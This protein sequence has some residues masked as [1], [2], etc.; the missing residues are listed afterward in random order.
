[1][2]RI[3][4]CRVPLF[5]GSEAMTAIDIVDGRVCSPLHTPLWSCRRVID[6]SGLLL[7]PGIVDIH[8]DAFERQIMPRPQVFFPLETALLETDRQLLANGI[9]TAFHGITCSWEPGLRSM[10]SAR[11][12]IEALRLLRPE[13][14]AEHLVHLRYEVA[15]SK[16]AGTIE[17]W[18][19]E[20]QVH[21][22]SFNDHDERLR[23]KMSSAVTGSTILSRT[24]LTAESLLASLQGLE[25]NEKRAD[26]VAR[27]AAVCRASGIPMASHD[28]DQPQTRLQYHQLGSAICEFPENFETAG[29]A[30]S[31]G[32][33]VVMGA[34]NILR[35]ESH[36]GLRAARDFVRQG[37]C[38]ILSSD[39]YYAG[40]PEAPFV[41]VA[42]KDLNLALAWQL[43]SENPARAAGLHD[44]GVIK[45]GKR[46]DLLLVDDRLPLNPRIVAVF[47]RGTLKLLLEPDRLTNEAAGRG[48]GCTHHRQEGDSYALC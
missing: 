24:G 26:A 8:G 41:L 5:S 10:D 17:K 37:L 19:G 29:Y 48:A 6:G 15:N 43:V 4:N 38:T 20:G 32:N 31:L 40:L 2:I 18:M 28:D 11:N 21:L 14:A 34:P 44:R 27:L 36:C 13:L 3:I 1:M 45:A 22:F 47:V 30:R 25:S 46:A 7:L 35:G 12:C 9:T 42:Q 33:D 16:A 39:Y 23:K